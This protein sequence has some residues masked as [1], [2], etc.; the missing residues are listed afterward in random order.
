MPGMAARW[1][2]DEGWVGR[3]RGR[4]QP[5]GGAGR[6]SREG[7]V[8]G[9]GGGTEDKTGSKRVRALKVG[10]RTGGAAERKRGGGGGGRG[11]CFKGF[12]LARLE[13][14]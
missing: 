4:R 14:K 7:E 9:R 3:R 11:W 13:S 1:R 12:Y 6:R 8:T 2:E 10:E 5:G